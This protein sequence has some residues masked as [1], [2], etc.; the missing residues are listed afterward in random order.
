MKLT[1][2][3]GATFRGWFVPRL[4]IATVP[5]IVAGSVVFEVLIR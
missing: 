4:L 3:Y 1:V 5:L 2:L